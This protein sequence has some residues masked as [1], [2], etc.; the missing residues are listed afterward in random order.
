MFSSFSQALAYMS[1]LPTFTSFDHHIVLY[2]APY[3]VTIALFAVKYEIQKELILTMATLCLTH[4]FSSEQLPVT[5]T[6]DIFLQF[7][8]K[9]LANN[10]FL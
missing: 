6:C 3:Q 7:S 2:D 9:L 8:K 4:V 5:I 1:D 10:E